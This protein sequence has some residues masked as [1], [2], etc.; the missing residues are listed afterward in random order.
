M[1]YDKRLDAGMLLLVLSLSAQIL[2]AQ[3]LAQAEALWKA[4]RFKEAN[5]VFKQLEAKEPKNPDY[6]VR[7]GRMM[8]DHAQPTDAQDLFGEDPMFLLIRVGI[9]QHGGHASPNLESLFECL[10]LFRCTVV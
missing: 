5:D 1:R 9:H 3:T 10:I 6:K 4:R 7:W 8:M 2:S